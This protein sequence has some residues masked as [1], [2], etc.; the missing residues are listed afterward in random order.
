MDK[1]SLYTTKE[2]KLN[3]S[4]LRIR[5]QLAP[6]VISPSITILAASLNGILTTSIP[7][8]L[9]AWLNGFV[10]VKLF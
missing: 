7:L 8:M 3:D 1:R 6:C 4:D 5:T 10:R 2:V 9:R